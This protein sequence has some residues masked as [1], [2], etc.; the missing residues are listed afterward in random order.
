MSDLMNRRDLLKLAGMG[1]AVFVSGTT[2][3]ASG[4]A[5]KRDESFYFVQLSD[6]HWGFNG[7]NIN[8]DSQGTLKKAVAAVNALDEQPDF[9]VFTGD[10]TQTT[11]DRKI[12][13]DRMAEFRDIVSQLKVK[14]VRFMP[15]E[16]DASLD[17]GEASTMSSSATCITHSITMAFISSSWTTSRIPSPPSAKSHCSGYRPSFTGT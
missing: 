6:T 14:T 12:R 16:H 8:A 10:L 1:V 17:R 11:D 4:S 3:R 5:Q 7:P 9:V 13:R 2:V 15:G